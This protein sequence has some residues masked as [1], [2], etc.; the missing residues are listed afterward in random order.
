MKHFMRAILSGVLS[1][2][3]YSLQA[4][5]PVAVQT[6]TEPGGVP[7]S[8]GYKP[9][10]LSLMELVEHDSVLRDGLMAYARSGDKDSFRKAVFN[11]AQTGNIGAELFLGEQYIPEQCTFEINQDVPHCGKNG[12]EP[13]RVVFRQNLLGIEASY[14]EAARWLE[15]ASAHGSGEASEVLAQLIT[16]M[17][18]NGHGTSYTT[19][20]SARFHALAR[21]QGFDVELISAICYKL[22]PGASGIRLG[23]LPALGPGEPSMQPFTDQELAALSS[24]GVS[25]SLLYDGG[26]GSGES[27][28]LSRP[29]GPVVH[30][31]VIL[32]HDPGHEVLLPIPAHR[33]VIYLQRGDTFLAFPSGG[34][35]L[36]RFLALMPGSSTDPQMS[37]MKQLMD[38]AHTGGFCTRFP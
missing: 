25:G 18:A 26:T 21:S 5:Q 28:L 36:P 12:N 19:P 2:L 15:K 16:R 6:G 3:A 30:I 13:P 17:Q 7:S 9:P 38:G 14:E 1:L 8:G 22:V 11:A 4:Q 37:V 24:S 35:N 32:D 34:Q 33:D 20:D 29:E 23:P 27:V 10:A 31:R